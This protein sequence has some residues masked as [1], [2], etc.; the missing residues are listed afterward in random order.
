[1]FAFLRP[2]NVKIWY[3]IRKRVLHRDFKPLSVVLSDFV[4]TFLQKNLDQMCEFITNLRKFLVY[5]PVK[6]LNFLYSLL[7]NIVSAGMW[8][9][10]LSIHLFCR[11]VHTRNMCAPKV[12][13]FSKMVPLKK[14]KCFVVNWDILLYAEIRNH[15]F[16]FP[17]ISQVCFYE[18]NL[19]S[20]AQTFYGN[21]LTFCIVCGIKCKQFSYK[22]GRNLNYDWFQ[23][24]YRSICQFFKRIL[25]RKIG[26]EV[27]FFGQIR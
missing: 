27:Q 7:R 15:S 1:M 19:G 20:K 23:G 12:K 21:R 5:F 26:N 24:P 4:G 22:K 18:E 17:W 25:L 16:M 9:R 10:Y 8:T 6:V 14:L 2:L 13:W 11:C 3:G